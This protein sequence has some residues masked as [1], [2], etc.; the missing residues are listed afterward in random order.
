MYLY[1]HIRKHVMCLKLPTTYFILFTI[2][3]LPSL[4]LKQFENGPNNVYQITLTLPHL[5]HHHPL[6]V[7]KRTTCIIMYKPTKCHWQNKE[8]NTI[9]KTWSNDLSL[10]E[11]WNHFK[12][13]IALD[14]KLLENELNHVYHNLSIYNKR[15]PLNLV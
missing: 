1:I 14:L 7:K 9:T 12:L 15:N 10:S 2:I 5:N 6:H 4:K 8:P 11:L 13:P 3:K